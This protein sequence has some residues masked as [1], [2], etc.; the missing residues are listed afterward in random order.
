MKKESLS[1]MTVKTLL[2]VLLFAGMGTIIIGGGYIIWEYSKNKA[3]NQIVKPVDQETYYQELA[4]DCEKFKKSKFIT[5]YDCCL[6]SVEIMR[7]GN[8]KLAPESIC[9]DGF[10]INSLWC[11]GAYSWCEPIE[12]DCKKHG[13]I[14]DYT[15]PGDDMSVQCCNDLKHKIQKKYFDE[16]CVN[17][18]EKHGYGGYAGICINCGDGIC[19][20]E[21][22]SKCNCPEDCGEEKNAL[23]EQKFYCEKDNDCLATCSSPGCYNKNWY[24]T[25]MRGDCEMVITHSCRCVENECIKQPLLKEDVE[26]EIRKSNYCDVEDDCV[27]ADSSCSLGCN[28]VVNKNKVERIN[29]LIGIIKGK[30]LVDC[31]GAEI[32]LACINNKCMVFR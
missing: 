19:D 13:E 27:R 16:N 5:D 14:P 32:D 10:Q 23:D 6:Q 26:G 20:V 12:K 8:F 30:C 7:K 3:S 31:G 29:K 28:V 11:G 4:K 2:A 1:I 9:S 18:Y 17:L 24:E 22:E 15:A 21:F 25:V